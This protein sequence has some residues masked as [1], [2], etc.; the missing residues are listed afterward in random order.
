M[1]FNGEPTSIRE[2]VFKH[3]GWNYTAFIGPATGDITIVPH[4]LVLHAPQHGDP[5]FER[6]LEFANQVLGEL[7]VEYL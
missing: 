7:L 6:A 4:A 3:G 1:D 5:E 2:I